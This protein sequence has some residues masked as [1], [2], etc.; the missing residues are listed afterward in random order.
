MGEVLTTCGFCSCGCGVYVEPRDGRVTA[1][2]PSTN[3]PVS[4]GRLCIK[5]WNG[6]PALLGADRLRTPL[7]RRRD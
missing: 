3:H 1:V 6:I 4:T 5:G 7:I 2:C